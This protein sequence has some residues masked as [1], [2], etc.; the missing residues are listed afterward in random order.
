M[1]DPQILSMLRDTTGEV[2]APAAAAE[3]ADPW[4]RRRQTRTVPSQSRSRSPNPSRSRCRSRG[5]RR[6]PSGSRSASPHRHRVERR[7]SGSRSCAARVAPIRST[8]CGSSTRRPAR[9]GS[10]PIPPSCSPADDDESTTCRP[11]S[12]AAASGRARRPAGSP[13]YAV[14]TRLHTRRVRAR[15]PAV[16]RRPRRRRGPRA[17]GR[18]AGVRPAARPAR[19]SASRTSAARTLCVAELDGSW[20]VLAGGDDEP[21]TVTW[22]SAEFVAA[23]EMGRSAGYWWSPDGTAIAVARVDTRR[24]A[25]VVHRRSRRT[26]DAAR[27]V[28]L[29]V[30]RHRQRGRVAAHRRSS[31]ARSSTSSGTASASST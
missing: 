16:R 28:P 26:R 31:T 30:R 21:G 11:R 4:R 6:E 22:G 19:P 9:N 17:G 2:V 25:A 20:R 24:R 12:G 3:P 18:R 8:G 29:S 15:R 23:E 10:S 27:R 5:S 14:D 13:R 7:A 1:L